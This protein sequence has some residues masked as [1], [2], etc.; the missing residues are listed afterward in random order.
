MRSSRDADGSI[1]GREVPGPRS[2]GFDLRTTVHVRRWEMAV[3]TPPSGPRPEL[4]CFAGRLPLLRRAWSSRHPQQRPMTQE[5]LAEEVGVDPRTVRD[6]EKGRQRPRTPR[7]VER[8]ATALEVSQQEL[9]LGSAVPA[10]TISLGPERLTLALGASGRIEGRLGIVDPVEAA[11]AGIGMDRRDFL[12]LIGSLLVALPHGGVEAAE[13]VAHALSS[14]RRRV[15]LATAEAMEQLTTHLCQEAGRIPVQHLLPD[16]RRHL[17]LLVGL[18]PAM[19]PAAVQARLV[20]CIGRMARLIGGMLRWDLGDLAGAHAYHD[21]A[22]RA[23]REVADWDLVALT[24]GDRSEAVAGHATGQLLKAPGER[25]VA[26]DRIVQALALIDAA[27]AHGARGAPA[28]QVQVLLIGATLYADAGQEAEFRRRHEEARRVFSGIGHDEVWAGSKYINAPMLLS[29]EGLGLLR[30]GLSH[31]AEPVMSAALTALT[32]ES[33]NAKYRC[34]AYGNHA[35]ALLQRDDPAVEEACGCVGE[36]LDIATTLN[37]ATGIRGARELH[38]QLQPWNDT[39]P[40]RELTERLAAV[41][42]SH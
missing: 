39:A 29:Y 13:R 41:P 10:P 3:L 33:G 32:S 25:E 36:M 30:L 15:D 38:R 11:Y 18:E 4:A 34:F 8:I 31:A 12:G 21:V 42:F 1:G 9:G 19:Q 23:A 35:A 5:R 6:W 16:A 24:L 27:Q 2:G 37:R 20:A 22:L 7:L 40:V 14:P 17:Q 28:L 26:G